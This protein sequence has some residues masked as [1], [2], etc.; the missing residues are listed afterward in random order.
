MSRFDYEECKRVRQTDPGF[1]SL[2]MAAMMK[3]DSTNVVK[4]RIVFPEV[5]DELQARYDAPG[6]ILPGDPP[7]R[8][9]NV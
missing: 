1:Y 7:Y 5:W 9:E 3:A 6:G 4:L 8:G 2:L